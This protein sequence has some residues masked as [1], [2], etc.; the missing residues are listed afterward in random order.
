MEV[1]GK[2]VYG[3]KFQIHYVDRPVKLLAYFLRHEAI[4]AAEGLDLNKGIILTGKIGCG[5][6]SLISLLKP[7]ADE[8]YRPV[9]ASC[10]QIS[11]K[12]R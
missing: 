8:C 12:F 2:N 10:R 3:P 5:K 11:L 6:T 4:A 7:L 1:H 9:M